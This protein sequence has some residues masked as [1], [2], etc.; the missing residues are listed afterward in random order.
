MVSAISFMMHSPSAQESKVTIQ[1]NKVISKSNQLS[2]R[3]SITRG[4]II[5]RV[6]G[7]F[8]ENYKNW[9]I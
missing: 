9:K 2:P 3:S 7:G 5:I 8:V 1:R 6:V 4:E